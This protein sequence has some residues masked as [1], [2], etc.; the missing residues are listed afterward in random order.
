MIDNNLTAL[1]PTKDQI[2]DWHVTRLASL[3]EKH[4]SSGQK[5]LTELIWESPNYGMV[6]LAEGHW[7]HTDELPRT[8][9]W[10]KH[11]LKFLPDLVAFDRHND[12]KKG[13]ELAVSIAL[14]WWTRFKDSP[15]DKANFPW[16]DHATAL[17]LSNLLLLRSHI[18]PARDF[19]LEK[20]CQEHAEVLKREDFYERGNN[21]GF[22][23]S[24]ILFE[25]AHEMD[26]DEGIS[27]SRDR[28]QF[29]ISNAFASDGCHIE[30]SPGYQNFGISQLSHADEIALA[31]TRT[32]F[33]VDGIKERAEFVLAHMTRPDCLLPH[34]GDT[35]DF[36]AR[37]QPAP[38]S[39]D[40]I[41]PE[42]GWCFFRSGWD[43]QALQGVFKSGYLSTAHRHDDDL[44][45]SL[46][47]LGEEWII[48]GGLFAHQP[49][50]PRRIYM[51][52][53]SAHSLPYVVGGHVTRNI[54]AIGQ[55]SR[56]SS[57]NGSDAE[58]A[59]TGETEMWRGFKAKRFMTFNRTNLSI[60]IKDTIEPNRGASKTSVAERI[61]QGGATYGTRF[62]VPAGKNISLVSDGVL[63]EGKK[64]KL[65]IATKANCHV[66]SGQSEPNLAG[67]RSTRPSKIEPAFDVSFLV[68]TPTLNE[69]FT[70][71]WR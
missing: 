52:S 40:F 57:S 8:L 70:L 50:D 63:I 20:I 65:H 7:D 60:V 59:V 19:A 51:R 54:E 27:V 55:H 47:A 1:S 10:E 34:I 5:I 33:G 24:I 11:Q 45:L 29:E 28:I 69:T 14:E 23:Q 18:W 49:K 38:P 6:S 4:A 67:W 39:N 35:A 32:T 43:S 64:G 26:D 12:G 37:R 25:Y 16:H 42:T 53:A 48:D 68:K 36:T 46:F 3:T 17:R 13:R 9:A 61:A 22:D 31:Y 30:N 62:L 44:A 21:H 71:T 56:I 58:F 2:S 15:H 66:V 41:S